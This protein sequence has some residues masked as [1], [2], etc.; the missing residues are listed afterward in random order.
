MS[1]YSK[2]IE[3]LREVMGERAV[4]INFYFQTT[5]G[6]P[7]GYFKDKFEKLDFLQQLEFINTF[8]EE[9]KKVIKPIHYDDVR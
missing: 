1:K 4:E 5:L 3:K 8:A 6:F 2:K 7:F 9:H